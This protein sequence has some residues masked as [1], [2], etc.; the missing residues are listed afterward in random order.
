MEGR[1]RAR[2]DWEAPGALAGRWTEIGRGRSLHC[3]LARPDGAAG[4]SRHPGTPSLGSAS[5]SKGRSWP[6]L[7]AR[8][9]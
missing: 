3:A 2:I 6:A 7:G 1:G 4:V 9:P 5:A 8:P